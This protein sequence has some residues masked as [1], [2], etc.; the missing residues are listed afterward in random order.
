MDVVC[1]YWIW[2]FSQDHWAT[3]TNRESISRQNLLLSLF[4]H[5]PVSIATLKTTVT[6]VTV[7]IDS[8]FVK[9]AFS[10]RRKH[11]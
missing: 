8:E 7:S 1:I 4:R 3:F 11:D 5:A 9:R 2:M 6:M 10:H